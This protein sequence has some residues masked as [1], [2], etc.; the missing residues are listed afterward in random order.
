MY[1]GGS[2]YVISQTQVYDSLPGRPR[3]EWLI[4]PN[5]NSPEWYGDTNP[6]QP[7]SSNL[8]KVVF[9]LYMEHT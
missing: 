2:Y 7:C 9:G 4:V 3:K 8:C 6:I 1:L 5:I